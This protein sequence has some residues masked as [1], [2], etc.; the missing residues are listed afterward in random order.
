MLRQRS[1]HLIKA[2]PAIHERIGQKQPIMV[3][4][5]KSRK[6]LNSIK[7]TYNKRES[8]NFS[9]TVP[10][11]LFSHPQ[12]KLAPPSDHPWKEI[13]T[14][15]C[16]T[17]EL[18]EPMPTELDETPLVSTLRRGG[19]SQAP[20]VAEL[21]EGAEALRR[22]CESYA[23]MCCE[24]MLSIT[25]PME[26]NAGPDYEHLDMKIRRRRT[27]YTIVDRFN[28]L[29]QVLFRSDSTDLAAEQLYETLRWVDVANSQRIRQKKAYELENDS[30][31]QP[32][33]LNR[34]VSALAAATVREEQSIFAGEK[35][36][37]RLVTC[38]GLCR[39]YNV[40]VASFFALSPTGQMKRDAL[41]RMYNS[42]ASK[43]TERLLQSDALSLIATLSAL[44]PAELCLTRA[45][46]EKSPSS[47]RKASRKK[48]KKSAL[49]PKPH[50]N[51]TK[52]AAFRVLFSALTTADSLAFTDAYGLCTYLKICN[53]IIDSNPTAVWAA[54]SND[55]NAIPL[56]MPDYLAEG[57]GRCRALLYHRESSVGTVIYAE[58]GLL[59]AED[60]EKARGLKVHH[61]LIKHYAEGMRTVVLT[62]HTAAMLLEQTVRCARRD[63]KH[64]QLVDDLL[65]HIA[66]HLSQATTSM[67]TTDFVTTLRVL[68]R[69][70]ESSSQSS[71]AV[72]STEKVAPL[73]GRATRLVAFLDQRIG[74]QINDIKRPEDLCSLL[75]AMAAVRCRFIC[76]S[77]LEMRLLTLLESFS[78]SQLA[79]ATQHLVGIGSPP[80]FFAPII[81]FAVERSRRCL[82][83]SVSCIVRMFYPLLTIGALDAPLIISRLFPKSLLADPR[84][85]ACTVE[86]ASQLPMLAEL[87]AHHNDPNVG[88]KAAHAVLSYFLLDG[89][90]PDHCHDGRVLH[91]AM[92]TFFVLQS[93]GVSAVA[94][95]K[96]RLVACIPH[97]ASPMLV[98]SS[99]SH[100]AGILYG[101]AALTGSVQGAAASCMMRTITLQLIRAVNQFDNP[102]RAAEVPFDLW[103]D[104]GGVLLWSNAVQISAGVAAI[105]QR[106]T[107]KPSKVSPLC[108][109]QRAAACV[110]VRELVQRDVDA[111]SICL[112]PPSQTG[113]EKTHLESAARSFKAKEEHAMLAN[114]LEGLR[115]QA[116]ANEE[117]MRVTGE[118]S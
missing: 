86:P 82:K 107:K 46:S 19:E 21:S 30:K 104:R 12:K 103:H 88:L 53:D 24:G 13:D 90:A 98:T 35:G 72:G 22:L 3:D 56:P 79:G 42:I 76:R 5:Q 92:A 23:T 55:A 29:R 81:E 100:S 99:A 59:P 66:H 6:N 45:E 57:L 114:A 73:R 65:Q 48:P 84:T 20:K 2:K 74:H 16:E 87:L 117:F 111:A 4:S 106:V 44:D 41:D 36:A 116:F 28:E 33:N 102:Q 118:S 62:S 67:H 49:P 80:S 18:S 95:L 89:G 64:F 34:E 91:A 115:I 26:L 110:L 61:K 108:D 63:K 31:F 96:Q 60:S 69:A 1:L 97:A 112:P 52:V 77:A 94:S 8:P 9:F 101:V 27:W 38:L 105:V 71:A 25:T 51:A 11:S 75:E 54:N 39:T 109:L 70:M 43:G 7:L 68:A 83:E 37:A 15:F 14:S 47:G 78:L 58:D 10:T 113:F 32:L 17:G 85:L 93:R 40:P 50:F